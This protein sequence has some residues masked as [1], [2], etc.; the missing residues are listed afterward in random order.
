[1][2]TMTI[3][4]DYYMHALLFPGQTTCTDGFPSLNGI[5]SSEFPGNSD[6]VEL[7]MTSQNKKPETINILMVKMKRHQSTN[8]EI[9][10]LGMFSW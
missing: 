10:F 4:Y 5:S 1:M 8:Q 9:Q 3:I 2:N 7:K 6:V